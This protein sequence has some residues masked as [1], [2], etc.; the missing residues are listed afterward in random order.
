MYAVSFELVYKGTV[1][2]MRSEKEMLEIIISAAETDPMIESAFL[3]GSRAAPSAVK[4]IYQDYDIEYYVKDIKPYWNNKAWL[5]SLFGKILILQTPDIMDDPSLTAETGSKFTYLCIYEDGVRIDLTVRSAPF[6]DNG[7]PYIV[8]LDKSG[9]LLKARYGDESIYHVRRPSQTEFSNCC[10]EFWWCLNNVAKGIARDEIPYAMAMLNEPVRDM[11]NKMLGYYI[12]TLTDFSV[13]IGKM[14]KYLKRYLP[15]NIY[16]KY[17]KTY[18][19]GNAERIW[20]AVI[21][22]CK[23][24]SD[25]AKITAGDFGLEYNIDE[26]NGARRY[27]IGVRDGEYTRTAADYTDS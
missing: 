3:C 27:I 4:D 18:P 19:V 16:A 10:N 2:K 6:A 9:K 20:T 23:L 8:L 26:E 24:F 5:E 14:G 12:G 15:E 7:E 11:L 22:V 13:S 1:N 17:L 25:V 21:A